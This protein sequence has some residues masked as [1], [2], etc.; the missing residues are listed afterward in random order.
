MA[1]IALANFGTLMRLTMPSLQHTRVGYQL[2]S[3][4]KSYNQYSDE[5][6]NMIEEL[7][8]T[9]KQLVST[10]QAVDPNG[11]PIPNKYLQPKHLTSIAGKLKTI[12]AEHLVALSA[13][14]RANPTIGYRQLM[15]AILKSPVKSKLTKGEIETV[16][17]LY[18]YLYF[19]PAQDDDIKDQMNQNINSIAII[20]RNTYA[21]IDEI[22]DL[23]IAESID[24]ILDKTISNEYV[25]LEIVNGEVTRKLSTD[26]NFN[27]RYKML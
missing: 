16:R 11:K 1:Y 2:K 26:K 5:I 21:S 6:S 8:D 15:K 10:F 25:S 3:D 24:C 7:G 14:M 27:I 18:N 12:K 20:K 19:D 9:V 4:L 22:T 17:T 13:E 23:V